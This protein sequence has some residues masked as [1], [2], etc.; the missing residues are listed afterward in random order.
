MVFPIFLERYF[1]IEAV[2][3]FDAV[4]AFQGLLVGV[5]TVLLFTIPPLLGIRYIRPALIFRREMAAPRQSLSQWWKRAAASVVSGVL[6][7]AFVGALAAWLSDSARTGRYFAFAIA[8]ALA[9]LAAVAWLLLRGLRL[10]SRNLP[11]GVGPIVRQGI[12]NLY[13][14]GNHAG[15]AVMALG[16]GVM[17]TVTIW[18]VQ[19][20]LLQDIVRTAP[21]GMPNV[22]LIDI[23]ASNRDAVYNLLSAQPGLEG[24]PELLGAVS[25]QMQSIDGTPVQRERMQGFARRYARSISVSTA[26][27]KP[28]FTEVVSGK[29]WDA[30]SHPETPELSVAEPAAKV[31]NLHVGSIVVWTSPQK[32]FTSRVVAIHKSESVRL[33]ARFE[34]FFTPG[35]LDGLPAIYYGGVRAR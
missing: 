19:R 22:Y 14:P 13:R 21:P 8:A 2:P 16:V 32:T 24:K 26:T 27:E 7:L 18:I 3:R 6:I 23:T 33:T 17:F 30:G 5:L 15:A 25:L 12:A 9:S 31:L 34:L 4:S 11:R 28:R 1:H 35:A 10:L 20:G 29:W